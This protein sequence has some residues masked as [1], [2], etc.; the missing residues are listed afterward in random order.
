M[1]ATASDRFVGEL[2]IR[3]GVIDASALALAMEARSAHATTL[4]R[5]LANLGIA[6]ESVAASVVA[7]ALHLEYL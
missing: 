3:T 1:I 5:A 2:L 4:V 7:S 6:D